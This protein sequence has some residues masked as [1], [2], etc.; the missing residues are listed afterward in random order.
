MEEVTN[1]CGVKLIP[2]KNQLHITLYIVNFYIRQDN[3]RIFFLPSL[4]HIIILL[5]QQISPKCS[6][7]CI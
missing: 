1:H 4:I 7:V 2:K 5:H 3:Y 6:H